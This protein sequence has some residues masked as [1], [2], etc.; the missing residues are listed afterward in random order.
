MKDC[1]YYRA[2]MPEKMRC[3][4]LHDGIGAP[5]D[6]PRL[7]YDGTPVPCTFY[8][9]KTDTDISLTDAREKETSTAQRSVKRWSEEEIKLIRE[10]L[11]SG[12]S[13]KKIGERLGRT[14][15]AVRMKYTRYI[16]ESKNK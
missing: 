4:I 2:A 13:Y 3:K 9:A 7:K 10:L 11:Y 8:K 12:Y 14:S 16:R 6:S 15:R 5:C 1:I